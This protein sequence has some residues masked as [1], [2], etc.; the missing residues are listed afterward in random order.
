MAAAA[1]SLAAL[2]YAAN[3]GIRTEIRDL[4]EQHRENFR[5]LVR[6]QSETAERIAL[7]AERTARIEGIFLGPQAALIHGAADQALPTEP[8][9]K[10]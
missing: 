3:R 10:R 7:I 4:V 8:P 9:E 2:I 5:E 1:V 6:Q